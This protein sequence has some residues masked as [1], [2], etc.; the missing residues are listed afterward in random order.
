V[1]RGKHRFLV[2]VAPPTSPHPVDRSAEI[3][4]T[5]AAA[6]AGIGPALFH[7]DDGLIVQDYV[8]GRALSSED[9]RDRDVQERLLRC[10]KICR[11][12]MP[13]YYDGPAADRTPRA[14][15]GHY[16]KLLA[17]RENRWREAAKSWGSAADTVLTVL[18]GQQRGLVHGDIHA[19][20]LLDDGER[21]WVIDWEHAGEGLPIID[22]AS[23]C[24]DAG[25]LD[26]RGRKS[27]R[28][29]WIAFN[30]PAPD[31]AVW[32]ASLLSAALRDLYWG[33]AQQALGEGSIPDS[34]IAFNEERASHL[35]RELPY[36]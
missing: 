14:V 19:G 10:L 32:A 8:D 23:A 20:N 33:Y 34:Y 5:R 9:L 25:L 35:L 18:E 24:I 21:L 17:R 12:E 30:G 16:R 3:A 4:A 28:D 7:V 6:M 26:R 22:W 29:R 13:A 36:K 31:P 11:E 1:L 2:R 27:A 15:L